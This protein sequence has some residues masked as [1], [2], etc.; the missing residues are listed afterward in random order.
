MVCIIKF[1]LKRHNCFN[2][3]SKLNA[4]ELGT[5]ICRIRLSNTESSFNMLSSILFKA[6]KTSSLWSIVELESTAILASGKNR[7]RIATVSSMIP[8]NSGCIVGSPFPANVITSGAILPLSWNLVFALRL[9][10][11]RTSRQFT[12]G[13]MILIQSTF[14]INA[15]KRA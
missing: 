14:A 2:K 1:P 4:G 13:P 6:W 9:P 8:P 5:S 10:H 11:F 12:M 15:I 3:D 7:S